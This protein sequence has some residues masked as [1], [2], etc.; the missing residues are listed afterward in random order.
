[1]NAAE[2]LA[3]LL[4]APR[5]A[6]IEFVEHAPAGAVDTGEAED[7]NRKARPLAEIKPGLLGLSPSLCAVAVR[8]G[9]SG[10]VDPPSLLVAIDAD[11][12]EIADP[13]DRSETCDPLAIVCKHSIATVAGWD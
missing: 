11:G 12:R 6:S 8:L 1:M 7:L 5:H 4:D 3:V 2:N 9:L 10:L 13:F